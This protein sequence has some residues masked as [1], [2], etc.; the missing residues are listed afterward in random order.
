MS[1]FLAPPISDKYAT[2]TFLCTL[3][4]TINH[5]PT[6]Y[7]PS[8]AE[9]LARG[10]YSSHTVDTAHTLWILRALWILLAS[11]SNAKPTA[12]TAPF[13]ERVISTVWPTRSTRV[14]ITF[15]LHAAARAAEKISQIN[16]L[17]SRSDCTTS[18]IAH[19]A[20]RR[21]TQIYSSPVS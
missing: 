12:F 1:L 10:G 2:H 11:A 16:G 3:F 21:L 13:V 9:S 15:A 20:Q 8:R 4:Y 17:F 14:T 5:R 18:H 6:A 7:R 19:D